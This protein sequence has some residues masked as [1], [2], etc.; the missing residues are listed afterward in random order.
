MS[1]MIHG[2]MKH[3]L[4]RLDNE[5]KKQRYKDDPV[6]WAEDR[7]GVILWSKQKEILRSLVDNKRTAVKSC[8]SIGKTFL[9]ALAAGWWVDTREYCMVQSTAPTYTQ[10]HTLLWEEIR[11]LQFTANLPGRVNL[12][13]QWLRTMLDK[14]TGRMQEQLVG[15][16]KRPADNNIHGFHGTHRPDGV[17]VILDEGCGIPDTLFT[18]SEAITTATFDRILTVGNPDDPATTFGDIWNDPKVASQ[19]N[20]IT[21][22]AFETPNFTDEGDELRK[23]YR[24]DKDKLK[25][26]EALLAGMPQ[27]P[28]I[29]SQKHLWGDDSPR[30]LS[31]VLAVFPLVS[32][33]SLFT[34]S[35]ISVSLQNIIE[36]G[37]NDY[38]VFGVDPARYGGDKATVVSNIEGH[39]EIVASWQSSDIMQLAASVHKLAIEQKIDQV[40]VDGIGVGGGVVDRLL[41]L[42]QAEGT[43][44][45]V[46]EMNA[47]GRAPDPTL[48]R[49]ARA[50]WYDTLKHKM[51]SGL[52]DL[53]DHRDILK[54]MSR[55]TYDY[56][57]GVLKLESKEDM[58]KRGVHSPDFLDAL[59]MAV[60][61]I[62]YLEKD[63][64]A[65]A[66]VGQTFN[67][68]LFQQFSTV[69]PF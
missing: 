69:S 23:K 20:K 24:H 44:Y 13:D 65:S 61:P 54:E 41:Q 18:G 21:V 4:D 55:V 48:H 10:V 27:P 14:T 57:L 45:T 5:R 38:R 32:E 15:E 56:P 9:S 59:V 50:Y 68:N 52:I 47:G 33:D 63:P 2:G 62:S 40:R 34:P 19:W 22:S 53:P 39:I 12:Q 31:K 1:Q 17:L 49:N 36:P 29:E 67:L 60:A 7:V 11:K 8:H 6:F 37:E 35:E 16:G 42:T 3:A 25:Q 58:R 51:R 30:Y 43:P 46:I 64:L 26:V 28:T 66:R